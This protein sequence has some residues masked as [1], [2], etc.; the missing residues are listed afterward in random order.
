MAIKA[1]WGGWCVTWP[2]LER[3][4]SAQ[5]FRL[6][7]APSSNSTCWLW[8]KLWEPAVHRSIPLIACLAVAQSPQRNGYE[9]AQRRIASSRPYGRTA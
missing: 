3:T 4:M 1:P 9:A 5:G 7:L 6:G 2:E 8:P